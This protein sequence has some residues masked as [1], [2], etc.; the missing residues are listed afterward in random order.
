MKQLI[1]PKERKRGLP[2]DTD[3]MV[4]C[5]NKDR[6]EWA[7]AAVQEFQRKTGSDNDTAVGDLI[8]DLMHMCDRFP[9]MG[10]F[11]AQFQNGQ[12]H[13]VAETGK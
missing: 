6:A 5:S 7:L 2:P 11:G 13:Y 8:A 9:E 12:R 10:P 4:G 3:K 1:Q